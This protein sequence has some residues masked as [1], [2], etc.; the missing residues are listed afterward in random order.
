MADDNAG[1]LDKG[2]I[3]RQEDEKHERDRRG[4]HGSPSHKPTAHNG[5]SERS[6]S[7]KQKKEKTAAFL[8]DDSQLSEERLKA[9]PM[10]V[11]LHSQ[12]RRLEVKR[13]QVVPLQ[14]GGG[15]RGPIT[16]FTKGSHCNLVR[17]LY[18]ICELRWHVVLT[19]PQKFPRC[20]DDAKKN[21][22]AFCRWVKTM[23]LGGVWVMEFQQGRG[24][25]HFHLLLN[26]QIN[27]EDAHQKWRQI[28]NVVGHLPSSCGVQI[29]PI[30]D[31][32]RIRSYVAKY[33]TKEVPTGFIAVRRFHGSFG[34]LACIP[35]IDCINEEALPRL[36]RAIRTLDRKRRERQGWKR[37]RDSGRWSRSYG[38]WND[39]EMR[40]IVRLIEWANKP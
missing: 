38:K 23:G 29:E 12:E 2:H 28:V 16:E 26:G 35:T 5:R 34:K 20:G 33:H 27:P 19:Y 4:A 36:I 22:Q 7:E 6:N 14:S 40:A 32:Y 11:K 3:S 15:K 8:Y 25:P 24:A 13:Q 9:R 37:R 30:Y 17:K 18:S 31:Q 10:A 1:G 21:V 39:S